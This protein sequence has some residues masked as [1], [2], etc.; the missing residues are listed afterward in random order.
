MGVQRVY[1]RSRDA[2]RPHL[3]GA[4]AFR[5]IHQDA[6]RGASTVGCSQG[7]QPTGLAVVARCRPD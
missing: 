5:A 2:Q 6:G 3:G 1:D 4:G 7:H